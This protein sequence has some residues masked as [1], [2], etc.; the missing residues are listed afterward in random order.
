M[1]LVWINPNPPEK[2]SHITVKRS[3]NEPGAW[4]VWIARNLGFPSDFRRFDVV[5]G[6]KY[7]FW[8]RKRRC[9]C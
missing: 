8:E 3:E 2:T 4:F 5:N 9:A 7:L 1:E 6:P